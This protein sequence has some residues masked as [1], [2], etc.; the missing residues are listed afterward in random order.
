MSNKI[1]K[2]KSVMIVTI[3]TIILII[4]IGLTSRQ[5]E[6]MNILETWAGNA[7]SPFQRV[8]NTGANIIS[9]GAS[10][11]FSFTHLKKENIELEKEVESLQEELIKARL[12][13][14]ELEELRGLKFALNYIEEEDDFEPIVA[15]I[16]GKSPSNWFDIFTIDVGE[17]KGIKKDSVVL[18]SNGLVGRVYEAG[19]NWAKVIA[20]IDNNSSVSFQILR[21]RT[22]QGILSGSITNE[23][24]GYLFDPM[25]EV[26]VG[27][28]L[29]TSGL[30]IYPHGIIIG[31]V[32]EVAMSSDQLLKTVK[33]EPYVNFKRLNK[34]LVMAPQ[35]IRNE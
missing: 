34:V 3:V 32:I 13:R 24:T 1:F 33:V 5:R 9:E 28:K 23:L 12:N 25:A 31:E 6:E 18:A 8:V 11:I 29:I 7:A 26:V 2:N 20:I 10:S 16:V 4:I 19:E 15:N 21:D 17:N 30:G 35:I 27:D 14:D 22:F